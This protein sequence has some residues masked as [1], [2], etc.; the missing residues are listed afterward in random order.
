M[1]V[2]VKEIIVDNRGTGYT[3]APKVTIIG[4]GGSGAT[5]KATVSGGRVT[6]ITLDRDLD[7]L[8]F[9]EEGSGYSSP[10]VVTITGGG[11]SGATATAHIHRKTDADLTTA[12][13]SSKESFLA[14]IQDERMREFGFENLRKADLLRWGIFL[15]VNQDMGNRMQQESPGQHFVKIFTNVSSRDLL[16]P[17]PNS[18]LTTN[19]A[20]VQNPGWN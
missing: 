2:G 13:T 18:E 16:M 19:R 12:Q 1:S 15:E 4:G 9:Y 14:L 17:I 10:P 11:G 5:A 3:S 6:A 8:A 20:M 7:A